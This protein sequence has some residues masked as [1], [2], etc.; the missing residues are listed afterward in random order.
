[1]CCCWGCG[2]LLLLHYTEPLK[3]W[4]NEQQQQQ[5]NYHNALCRRYF[6]HHLSRAFRLVHHTWW[7][8]WEGNEGG[9]DYG[10]EGKCSISR[11]LGC[12]FVVYQLKI[13]VSLLIHRFTR[14]QLL[15]HSFLS[16]I[17]TNL[18]Y[19]SKKAIF[20]NPQHN[21]DSTEQSGCAHKYD[22]L[23]QITSRQGSLRWEFCCFSGTWRRVAAHSE[24]FAH[25]HT[26][27]PCGLF[28]RW[29]THAPS[30]NSLGHTSSQLTFSPA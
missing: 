7:W 10:R 18:R 26:D 25:Q 11:R 8:R 20:S 13:R 1:M 2:V 30:T 17:P 16:F 6:S 9:Y 21:L 24:H 22:F 5:Q 12:L 29:K 19:V 14:L 3:Q 4:T 27:A 28:R 15:Q 23:S